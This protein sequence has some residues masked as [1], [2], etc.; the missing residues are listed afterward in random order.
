M[1]P[2]KKRLYFDSTGFVFLTLDLYGETT[3]EKDIADFKA[4]SERNRETFD[5]IELPFG[6][7]VQDFAECIGYRV[8]VAELATLAEEQRG[9]AIKFAYPDPNAPTEPPVYQ[10]PLSA[11]IEEVKAENLATMEAVAEV[12]EMVLGGGAV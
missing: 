7:Y 11:Q 3:V 4:L 10:K 8:D 5:V 2:I 1:N 12:Y 6:A 9:E